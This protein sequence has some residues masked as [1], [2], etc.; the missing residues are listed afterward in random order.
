MSHAPTEAPPSSL[1]DETLVGDASEPATA[2]GQTVRGRGDRLGRYVVLDT[3]GRGGMGIVYAAYDPDLDRK[4][5]LKLLLPG[6]D[7]GEASRRRL[8]R[9]AQAIARLS[10]PNVVA[11]HDVGTVDEQVFVAMELV[12]GTS[13]G[14]WLQAAPRR[15]AEILEL[16]VQAG[17]GL[18]AAHAAGLVHRDF[19]PDNVLVGDD[20]RA[21]V[22]DFGL[23][24][25]DEPS[26]REPPPIEGI[27]SST[28][29]ARAVDL[30]STHAGGLV[31]TPAYMSP[32]Q[33]AGE[34][35]EARSDQFSLCVALYEAL[36]GERPFAGKTL[37]QLAGAVLRGELREPPPASRVPGRLRRVLRRGLAVDPAARYPD[38]EALLQELQQ[39]AAPRRARWVV[40]LGVVAA[41]VAGSWAMLLREDPCR[42]PAQR[43]ARLWSPERRAAIEQAF[44]AVPRPYAAPTWERVRDRLDHHVQRWGELER[45]Q[46]EAAEDPGAS[47]SPERVCLSDR[48]RETA[49]LLETLDHADEAVVTEA[50]GMVRSLRDPADCVDPNTTLEPW[51]ADPALREQV[52]EQ[53][54]ELQRIGLENRTGRHA[55]LGA[56]LHQLEEHARALGYEPLIVEVSRAQ[57]DWQTTSGQLDEAAELYDRSFADALRCGHDRLAFEVAADLLF[58]HGI[59]RQ[60]PSEAYAWGRRA[61]AL[62]RRIGVG[63]PGWVRLHNYWASVHAQAHDDD[64]LTEKMFREVLS[65]ARRQDEPLVLASVL[66]NFGAFLGERGRMEEARP[67]LEES[68]QVSG[69]ALDDEHPAVIRNRSNLAIMDVMNGRYEQGLAE[70][71]ALMEQQ[72][73]VLGDDHRD[74][75]NNLEAQGVALAHLGR[76]ER[77]EQVR[78]RVVAMRTEAYGPEHMR[79]TMA[80]A[81]LVGVLVSAGRLDAAETEL[82]DL[83]A[84]I[85]RDPG[86]I[87]ATTRART[88]IYSARA[89]LLRGR[90]QDA[91]EP[92]RQAVAACEPDACPPSITS[93]GLLV[94]AEAELVTGDA[95]AAVARVAALDPT[96][97]DKE[98]RARLLFLRARASSPV[99][100][101]P[102]RQALAIARE[103]DHESRALVP[104]IEAWIREHE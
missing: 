69:E 37:A 61:E 12:E 76:L 66:N 43:G 6:R 84:L 68:A 11:V 29:G 88:W 97:E 58:L 79:V 83:R 95:A 41:L 28:S 14:R 17:R 52:G 51:P 80:R 21:R 59:Q 25:R 5:A 53:R 49:V 62:R 57:A 30:R 9:E 35:G 3:L 23:A 33:L 38:V 46:C 92:A 47:E 54:D 31:G 64:A 15:R 18:A 48:L 81:N 77:S 26:P 20:G 2:R 99:S 67:L 90:P 40:G 1:G 44:L 60:A 39:A 8:L 34:A 4:V 7:G 103:G 24:R 50:V 72:L 55:E 86:S 70:L 102:A 75:V 85:E 100:L 65:V 19:K 82:A 56:R 42:E 91:L 32:E 13:L 98:R 96:K 78:R 36:Y 104:V 10:H 89:A 63:E 101:E 45:Q 73:V 22:A 27:E 74:V 71:E 93:D 94:L 16:F 87:P